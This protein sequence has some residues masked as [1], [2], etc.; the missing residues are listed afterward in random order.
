MDSI[1]ICGDNCSFCPRYLATQSG[2]TEE[3]EKVKELW[4]RLGLRDSDFPPQ[5]M[6]CYG[7]RPGNDCAYSEVRACAYG[8]GLE[9]CGLCQ[10]YPC[11]LLHAVFEKSEKLRS[12]AG[13]VCIPEEMDSLYKAFL[14][15]QQNLDRIHFDR[16]KADKKRKTANMPLKPPR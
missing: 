15:K 5:Y 14:C 4:V 7:C 11:E 13:H 8:K 9:N 2:E 6:A 12:H 10:V 16:D 3:L 1:G